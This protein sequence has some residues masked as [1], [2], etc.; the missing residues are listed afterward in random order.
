MATIFL[1]Y[2]AKV[3]NFAELTYHAPIVDS[4]RLRREVHTHF[5]ELA[6]VCRVGTGV[7]GILDL[8]QR[9]GCRAVQFELEDVDV[10]VRLDDAVYPS[11]ALL[12]LRV[13]H[14]EAHEAQ[15]QVEGVME[16]AFPFPL[17]VFAAHAVR[18]ARQEGCQQ[19][20]ERF[21]VARFQRFGKL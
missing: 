3:R 20:L 11:L 19:F 9:S 1:R 17:V 15:N 6:W 5:V 18:D 16:I 12:F 8:L 4:A 7:T 21:Q 14:V 13:Y 10:V 2:S